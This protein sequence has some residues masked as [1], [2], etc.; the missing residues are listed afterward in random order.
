MG[1]GVRVTERLAADEAGL[2]RAAAL[3][4]VG[5]LVAFPTET[6]Y[7]LGAAAN[8]AAAVAA[9]YAAKG[10]PA[11]NPL[12][13]HLPTLAAARDVGVLD[14]LALRLAEACWPGPLTLVVPPAA[15]ARLAPAVTAGGSTVGLRVPA[16]PLARRLLAEA[17]MPVAAPSANPSGRV[18]P[19][20]AAHALDRETGLGG[21]IDAVLDGGP[22]PVG[23]ESTVVAVS[24]GAVRVLR[25]GGLT[26]ERLAEALGT[27]PEA[28]GAGQG[29]PDARGRGA[30][31]PSQGD[32]IGSVADALPSPGML[33][34]HYAPAARLRLGAQA[35]RPGE[36]WLGFG[37]DPSGVTGPARSL[38]GRGDLAEA[39]ATLFAALR[40]L[41]SAV[42]PGGTIAVAAVPDTG[43]GRAINDRLRRAAAPR[44]NPRD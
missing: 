30:E 13:V 2:A 31:T 3:L 35:P 36:A 42:G 21:R 23:V 9:L 32:G 41:D 17:G 40:T 29:H 12:I 19:T 7:G 11:E 10:R 16:L 39:A 22:C 28:I 27:A 44:P 37:P 34:S 18:S 8:D 25:E 6:V 4:R 24:D 33:A 20:T 43:L 1:G 5:R 14:P 26:L 38:S 15:G